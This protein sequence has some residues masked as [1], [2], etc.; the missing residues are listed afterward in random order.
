[1]ATP[2]KG[3]ESIKIAE[4]LA[5]G[6]MPT[7]GFTTIVDIQD[8]SVTFD[9]PALETQ[10][11]TVED[12]DG[13]RYVLGTNQAGASFTCAS[14]D[15]EGTLVADLTGG[16]WDVAT[17]TFSAP[18][19]SN[20]INKAIQFTSRPFN[21]KKFTLNIPKAAVTFNFSG[22]FTKDDLVAIGFTGT[23]QVPTNQAGVSLSP[24]GF[25]IEDVA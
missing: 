2:V 17:K 9:V 11:Y 4:P 1:M 22:A 6:L 23:A 25:K 10:E 15:I 19:Q 24:W 7:T 14:V 8:G 20:I 13:A 3:V 16:T 12:V 21:G 5:T 18:V